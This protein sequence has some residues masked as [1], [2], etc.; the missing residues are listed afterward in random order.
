M[1]QLTGLMSQFK[2]QMSKLEAQ[3]DQFKAIQKQKL[4]ILNISKNDDNYGPRRNV[5][6]SWGLKLHYFL[7]G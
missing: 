7:V 5:K 6:N 4:S 3:I 2:A 1:G